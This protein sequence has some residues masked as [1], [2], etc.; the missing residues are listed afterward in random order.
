[1]YHLR[2][3]LRGRNHLSVDG[4][5]CHHEQGVYRLCGCLCNRNHLSVDCL[6]CHHKQG[7]YRLYCVC[8]WDKE[9][10]YLYRPNKYGMYGLR[11]RVHL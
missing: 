6:Y 1:M 11:R 2:G 5:Y 8:C 4:L 10:Q 7:V 9:K 3:C